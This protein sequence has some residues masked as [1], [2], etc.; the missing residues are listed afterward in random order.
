MQTIDTRRQTPADLR[1]TEARK[2]LIDSAA[3]QA[4]AYAPKYA[5]GEVAERLR[6]PA[7]LE[8]MLPAARRALNEMDRLARQQ[9]D[10]AVG[11]SDLSA[12]SQAE[13]TLSLLGNAGSEQREALAADVAKAA[14]K[15]REQR[16]RDRR[17][18][19][20]RRDFI[21]WDAARKVK[22]R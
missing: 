1:A 17:E 15:L 4:E 10:A 11:P 12:F 21:K 3:M 5:A 8:D 16:E 7:G 9:R 6:L 13:D 20:A 18:D 14:L 2:R 19:E 22:A